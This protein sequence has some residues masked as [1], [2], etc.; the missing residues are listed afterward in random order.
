MIEGTLPPHP[1]L[2][3]VSQMQ[4]PSVRQTFLANPGEVDVG[5]PNLP[6]PALLC[7][8]RRDAEVRSPALGVARPQPGDLFCYPGDPV[9]QVHLLVGHLE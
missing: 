6:L 1:V 8:T 9:S 3:H 4:A 2:Q 5:V 7:P